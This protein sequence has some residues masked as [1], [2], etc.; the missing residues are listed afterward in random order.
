MEHLTALPF[1]PPILKAAAAGDEKYLTGWTLR[2]YMLDIMAINGQRLKLD[3][4]ASMAGLMSMNPD[5]KKNLPRLQ[6]MFLQS[7]GWATVEPL[8]FCKALGCSKYPELLSFFACFAGDCGFQDS[9]FENFNTK[10]KLWWKYA[11]SYFAQ[12]GLEPH[13]AIVAQALRQSTS[14]S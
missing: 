13:P 11:E 7:E 4:N 10:V 6:K 1:N 12:H 3:A 2:A 8:E 5:K 9:D 14:D